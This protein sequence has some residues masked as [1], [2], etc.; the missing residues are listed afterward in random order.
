MCRT[1]HI[2]G[3]I[4]RCIVNRCLLEELSNSSYHRN[5]KKKLNE[6]KGRTIITVEL[7]ISSELVMF[8]DDDT[9]DD[10]WSN[11][12]YHRNLELFFQRRWGGLPSRTPHIIGTSLGGWT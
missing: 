5:Y 2:I 6:Y 7:L 10:D 1:P 3:T 8:K 4:L 9:E 11:S 12:S